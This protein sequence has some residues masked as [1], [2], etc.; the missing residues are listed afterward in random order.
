MCRVFFTVQK[1]GQI[2]TPLGFFLTS[3]V[4]KY[5]KNEG[6]PLGLKK[7]SKQN[8]HNAGKTE[9]GIL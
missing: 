6:D 7:F 4:V 1:L 3:I 8:S 9:R 2:G 5:Q